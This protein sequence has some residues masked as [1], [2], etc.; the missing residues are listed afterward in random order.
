[1]IRLDHL[2]RVERRPG[3]PT[4]LRICAPVAALG[5]AL[6]IVAVLLAAVGNNPFATYQKM[7]DV[8]FV[9]PGAFTS[10]LVNATPLLFT[11]LCAVVTFRMRVYNIG[12]EGQ[13]YAGAIATLLVALLLADQPSYIVM[14][15]MILTGALAGVLWVAIPGFLR[16]HLGTNE[17][18]TSLMLNYVAGL[19]MLYLIFDSHSYWRDLTSAAGQVYPQSK[20][21]APGHW[22]PSW[23]VGGTA[24]PFGLLLAIALAVGIFVM[25]KYTRLG[26]RMRVTAGSVTSA[27]YAGFNVKRLVLFVMILSG[28][29]AG[30]GGASQVGDFS[31][32]LDPKGLEAAQYGYTGIVVAALAAFDPLAVILSS[33]LLGALLNASVAL[34]GADFPQGLVGTI[35]GIIIFCVVSAVMFTNYRVKIRTKPSR[36]MGPAP[37]LSSGVEESRVPT[38]TVTTV[39]DAALN[40]EVGGTNS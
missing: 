2:V 39:S 5:C 17:I 22:W 36:T 3:T 6:I 7:F 18:L 21:V 13:L 4:W 8:A 34:N 9:N 30:L 23:N 33:I 35:E 1:V 16:S 38:P 24:I 37:A 32:N 25:F 15:A 27:R 14:P 11:G 28:V 10:T 31:H 19:F 12:G 40:D 20:S 29:L 26:F